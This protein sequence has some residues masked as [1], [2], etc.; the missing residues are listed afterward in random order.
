MTRAP[1]AGPA[2]AVALPTW[3]GAAFVRESVE[4]VL[5]QDNADFELIVCDDASRDGTW[6]ML[7]PYAVDARCR[8]LRNETN[9][10][11]FATLNRIVREAR[12]PWVHLWSQDDRML[13]S[14]LGRTRAFA[15]AH[16]EVGM[17]YSGRYHIDAAGRRR[18]E[19][20][21]DETPAIVSPLLAARIMF[22]FGSIA[23]NIANV[24]VRKDVFD[25]LGGFREDLAVSGDF[26]YWTR[27]SEG[28]P[29]G[30]QREPLIE[31]RDHQGQLS[32]QRGSG[33]RFIRENRA[34]LDRLLL[35]L[36]EDERPRARRYRRWVLEVRQFHHAVRCALAGD[37]RSC[38]DVLASLRAETA[39][40]P[41]ALR[42]LMSANGHLAAPPSL[43]A[44]GG[45]TG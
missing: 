36:P 27:V 42:W 30:F 8:L 40:V 16:A 26:E 24:T 29:I 23:G 39:L 6:A 7:E 28:W 34:I 12:S 10:G 1:S 3:N 14:C 37:V 2:I 32:R 18:P 4:S 5:A 20:L 38:L 25:T 19:A 9:R 22:Y 35:R 15:D 11:L 45:A 21:P 41:L 33:T 17:I 31:L 13:P 44:D 43:R